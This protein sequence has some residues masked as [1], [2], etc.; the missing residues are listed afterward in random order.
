MDNVKVRRVISKKKKLCPNCLKE[1]VT[2]PTNLT[3]I[4][5]TEYVCNSCEYRGP[6]ALENEK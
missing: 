2:I 3:G 6:I 1:L 4:L 5:P